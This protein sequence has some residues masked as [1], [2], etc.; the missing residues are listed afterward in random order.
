MGCTSR[1]ESRSATRT[2]GLAV[3]A[4]KLR[5]PDAFSGLLLVGLGMVAWANGMR[6]KKANKIQMEICFLTFLR[7]AWFVRHLICFGCKQ[8]FS[9]KMAS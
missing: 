5:V 2:A 4:T 8:F 3:Q 6:M 9:E 1:P 7:R